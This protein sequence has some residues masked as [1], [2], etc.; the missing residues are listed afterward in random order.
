MM[1]IPEAW[2][3]HESMSENKR[4]FYE[5]QSCLM[6]PWDGPASIAFT[7]GHY[8]GAVLDRNG[9]RPSRY[10]LTHD[11]RVIMASEV[12]VLPIDP[13]LVKSKGRLQP[14]R[15]FLIDFDEGRLLTDKELKNDFSNRQPYA[16]VVAEQPHRIE[17]LAT[18]QRTAPLRSGH[19]AGTHAG[20][21]VHDR[22]DAL[23]AAASDHPGAGSGR[24][25]GQRFG[26]GMFERQAADDLRLLQSSYSH[27]SRIPPSTRS[28]KKSSC[29]WSAISGPKGICYSRPR[30]T[31]HRLLIPHP[32]LTNEELAAI[33]HMDHRG[34]R[35]KTIDITF[36]R[37]EGEAGLVPAL[38]RICAEAEAAI[39]EGFSLVILS[40]RNVSDRR[41]AVSALMACGAVHHHLVRQSKT[42][43]DRDRA[44]DGR[45]SRSP[46][47]LPAGRLRRRRHQSLSGL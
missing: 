24:L 13:K 7:D 27:R 31:A 5:Y 43:S 32:I 44:G 36:S 40:D 2:Q 9:L 22:N 16:Q 47:S 37:Q 41:V 33:K 21:R 29:R 46:S 18:G 39:D 17:R 20:V 12:G 45:S 14:G 10:Y 25:H 23:H 30:S 42:D 11:D 26:A 35:T 6:E 3:K 8:I 1:M 38:D 28:A 19:A 4:A 15:M 34:W